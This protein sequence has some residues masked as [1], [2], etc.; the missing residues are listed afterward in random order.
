MKTNRRLRARRESLAPLLGS[1]LFLVKLMSAWFRNRE[2]GFRVAL[3]LRKGVN[4]DRS[5]HFFIRENP[6]CNPGRWQFG[7]ATWGRGDSLT[8]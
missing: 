4:W 3:K 2:A 1:T 7:F 5:L 6:K 8:A